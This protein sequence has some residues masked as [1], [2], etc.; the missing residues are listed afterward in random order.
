MLRKLQHHIVNQTWCYWHYVSSSII[1]IVN[2]AWC[3]W[4]Y[5]NSS[6][7]IVNQALVRVS[8]WSTTLCNTSHTTHTHTLT[9]TQYTHQ[10]VLRR[11]SP[12]WWHCQHSAVEC[13]PQSVWSAG[14]GL[15]W[16]LV[17]SHQ[18]VM[19]HSYVQIQRWVRTRGGS[20]TAPA[21]LCIDHVTNCCTSVS[22]EA[23]DC[24]T[25]PVSL[26]S[27]IEGSSI[28]AT[29]THNWGHSSSDILSG[30][31]EKWHSGNYLSLNY[32][33]QLCMSQHRNRE[34]VIIFKILDI[35]LIK[36]WF[37]YYT[38]LASQLRWNRTRL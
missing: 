35:N 13:S 6:I 34:S 38:M 29:I 14:W 7:I 11:L 17:Y 26:P 15:H 4:R 33:K 32:S 16:W 36:G 37:I 31:Q 20:T 22:T 23:H 1:I 9:H 10:E 30:S 3:Y 28:I 19:L 25:S 8:A 12:G 18:V 2:Q 5:V 21:T 27:S 24:W